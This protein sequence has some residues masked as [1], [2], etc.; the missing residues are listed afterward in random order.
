MRKGNL[1][2]LF[3]C[4]ALV[5]VPATIATISS[6]QAP[7]PPAAAPA[8][9][10]PPQ[11]PPSL[12]PAHVVDLMTA[13]GSAVFGAQWKAIEAKIVE[14]PAIANA[15]PEHKTTYDIKP[16]AG[17]AGFDDS[18]WP[19][20]EATGLAARRGGGKM[21]FIW[22]RAML[23]IPAKIGNFE[24]AESA[25]A[26]VTVDVTKVNCDQ[27]V[28]HKISEPR[29]I[30]AWLSSYYNAKR[31][32]RVIDLQTLEE[33]MSKVTNYCSDEKNFKVPVMKAVEQVLGKSN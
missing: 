8:P 19:V 4:V 6:A 12:V 17:E 2:R 30:A 10:P 25:Q 29:L 14:I 21:S 24:T 15:M 33:N 31:N 23:T 11:M 13:D 9:P 22:Y 18:S 27:F 26:Q 1:F 7:A 28:H 3:A 20:I 16:H 5:A 32:N